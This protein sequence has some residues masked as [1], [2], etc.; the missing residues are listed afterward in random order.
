MPH[1]FLHTARDGV[2]ALFPLSPNFPDTL[3]EDWMHP[4]NLRD[5]IG[6]PTRTVAFCTNPAPVPVRAGSLQAGRFCK[7]VRVSIPEHGIRGETV[8][9]L[10]AVAYDVCATAELNGWEILTAGVHGDGGMTLVLRK[11]PAEAEP[12]EREEQE[13]VP[14][15]NPFAVVPQCP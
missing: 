7:R 14:L 8:D 12:P 6:S 9:S 15:I 3:L 2:V 4:T 13:Y 11:P 5:E 10:D 1:I